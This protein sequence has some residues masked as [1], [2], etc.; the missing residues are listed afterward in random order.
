MVTLRQL[1]RRTDG[2]MDY[3]YLYCAAPQKNDGRRK[4]N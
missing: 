4:T 1:Y 2:R 3:V